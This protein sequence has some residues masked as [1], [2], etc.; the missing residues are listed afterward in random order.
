[1]KRLIFIFC[2]FFIVT[3]VIGQ[4]DQIR[5]VKIG[6]IVAMIDT[7]AC[8]LVINFWASWCQPCIHEIT[9]F[10]KNILP[11]Q[12]KG[13]KL[14]L[15]SLDAKQDYLNYISA[16]AAK[17]KYQSTII[18]LDEVNAEMFCSK[19]D[20]TWDGSIPVTLMINNK[21]N[22][23]RFFAHQLPEPRLQLELQKLLE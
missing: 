12:S 15:V 21:K 11:L 7:S 4:S 8:P 18:W 20:Q 16:F 13:V 9:W 14:I 17:K 5:K 22:Y 2:F 10:E 1:M 19:I 3:I 6:D 23:R